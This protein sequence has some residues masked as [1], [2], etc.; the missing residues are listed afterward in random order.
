[1]EREEERR[2][3]GR[4]GWKNRGRKEERKKAE[5]TPSEAE[6]N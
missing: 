6:G 2:K 3:E 4:E 5:T 1:M